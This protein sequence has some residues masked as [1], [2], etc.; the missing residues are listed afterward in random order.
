[1][2]LFNTVRNVALALSLVATVGIAQAKPLPV[3]TVDVNTGEVTE[4]VNELCH[5]VSRLAKIIMYSRISGMPFEDAMKIAVEG[6][7]EIRDFTKGLVL[8]A[9]LD[10]MYVDQSYV[11][12]YPNYFSAKYYLECLYYFEID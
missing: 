5:S 6:Q 8:E 4:E 2:S 10:P 9:Y 11:D 1:M 7:P 12:L 3:E